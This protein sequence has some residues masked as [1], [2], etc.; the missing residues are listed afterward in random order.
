MNSKV[1]NHPFTADSLLNNVS[2]S[3]W[4]VDKNLCY[5]YAN[6]CFKKAYYKTFGIEIKIGQDIRTTQPLAL[7]DF[8]K[9]YYQR[10]FNGENFTFEF[11]HPTENIHRFYEVSISPL[12]DSDKEVYGISL[13]SRDITDRKNIENNLLATQKSFS[14]ALDFAKMGNWNIDLQTL[15]L[16]LSKQKQVILELPNIQ[17]APILL[18]LQDYALTFVH[19]EDRATIGQKIALILANKSQV[20]YQLQFDYRCITH[21]QQLKYF[22]LNCVVRENEQLFGFTQDITE[23]KLAE[24]KSDESEKLYEQLV[25]TLP[26]M[27][28]LHREGII[29][30]ANETLYKRFGFPKEEVLGKSVLEFVKPEKITVINDILQ[31]RKLGKKIPDYELTLQTKQKDLIYLRVKSSEVF[32]QQQATTLI[33]FEDVTYLK[34]SEEQLQQNNALLKSV[35]NSPTHTIIFSLDAHYCYTSFND[36]HRKT[37][38][39]IWNCEIEVG[40]NMLDCIHNEEDKQKAKANFDKALAGES[41]QIME[42]Y[43]DAPNRFYYENA[44]NPI[45]DEAGNISGLTVFLFDISSLKRTENAL[46]KSQRET[47]ILFENSFDAA[48]LVEECSHKI[49]RCNKKAVALFEVENKQYITHVLGYEHFIPDSVNY[50][51]VEAALNAGEVWQQELEF[52]T[53]KG[54]IFWGNLSLKKVL[55]ASDMGFFIMKIVDI[56]KRKIAERKLFE[57]QKQLEA[58]IENTPDSIWLIDTHYRLLTAN[59]AFLNAVFK[60]H[61]ISLKEGDS[62]IN[63]IPSISL[64]D[65]KW[66]VNA[67][68]EALSGQALLRENSFVRDGETLYWENAL[69]P[70]KEGD[71]IK[72]VA[73]LSRNITERKRKEEAIRRSEE[74]LKYAIAATKEGVW[75]WDVKNKILKNNQAWYDILKFEPHEISYTSDDISQLIHEEDKEMVYELVYAARRG[76]SNFF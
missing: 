13:I 74:Q 75:D 60:Q 61:K 24:I 58:I 70:V 25:Q 69:F 34:K 44:Y 48:F 55:L 26:D 67:Y 22:H 40:L 6:E 46:I 1:P 35:I 37:M 15:T 38:R 56:S 32:I 29:L 21:T 64:A 3:I 51:E 65:K 16:S 8:W 73:V 28:L 63:D 50:A 14:E 54:N 76:E 49:I 9:P 43:G 72:G 2:D 23:R 11:S 39:Q 52:V 57:K 71:C 62:L 36:N 31:D 59:S 33:I 10:G 5:L 41:F 27:V 7:Q 45:K 68:D 47:N 4:A 53:A 17:E 12:Y 18:P 30:F 66:W 20:G 42:E 19:P